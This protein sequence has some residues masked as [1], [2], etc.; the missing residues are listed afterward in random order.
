VIKQLLPEILCANAKITV[1][2]GLKLLLDE[3]LVLP[4]RIHHLGVSVQKLLAQVFI[5]NIF[6]CLWNVLLEETD[7]SRNLLQGHAYIDR[8]SVLQVL[9]RRIEYLRYLPLAR[10]HRFQALLSRRKVSLHDQEDGVG[11]TGSIMFGDM[12]PLADVIT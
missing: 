10:N 6:E 1:G 2:P 9:P 12:L 3:T 4:E 11:D 8:W 7:D 5:L